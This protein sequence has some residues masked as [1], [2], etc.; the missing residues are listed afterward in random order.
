MIDVSPYK[1]NLPGCP[2]KPDWVHVVSSNI[3]SGTSF[4]GSIDYSLSIYID[5]Y[6]IAMNLGRVIVLISGIWILYILSEKYI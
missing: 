1:F 2:E 4:V 3:L 5:N 6:L